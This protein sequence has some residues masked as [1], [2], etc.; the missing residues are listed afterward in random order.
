MSRVEQS[1]NKKKILEKLLTTGVVMIVLD[2]RDV[3]VKVPKKF[4]TDAQLKLNIS[5]GFAH[6]LYMTVRGVEITLGFSGVFFDVMVPWKSIFIM[7][8]HGD[9]QAVVFPSD[10][11]K[12]CLVEYIQS[13]Q[14]MK[15]VELDVISNADYKSESEPKPKTRGHLRVVK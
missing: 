1:E 5:R 9:E 7:A 4:K 3:D 15:D 11:P 10:F 6:P 12:D 13:S 2:A 14:P 8:P